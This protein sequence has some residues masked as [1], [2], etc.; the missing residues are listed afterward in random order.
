MRACKCPNCGAN[1]TFDDGREYAFCQFCG[2][3]IDL[4]DQRTMHTEH[5]IDEAKIKESEA[6]AKNADS[7]HRVV[8]VFV[9]PFEE[10]KRKKQEQ[11]A[12]IR[13]FE[14]QTRIRQKELEEQMHARQKESRE[15]FGKFMG[16]L[17]VGLA[18]CVY[19]LITHPKQ[20]IIILACVLTIG[21][22]SSY[23]KNI[24]TSA[25]IEAGEV[26]YPKISSTYT[27]YRDV[28]KAL[29]DAGFKNI[30]AIPVHDLD[31]YQTY[32][33][34]EI[35]EMTVDGAP[36]PTVGEWYDAYTPIV[37]KYHVIK[38]NTTSSSSSREAFDDAIADTQ[39]KLEEA[40]DSTIDL[41]LATL[42][43]AS[44]AS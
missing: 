11:E 33:V 12:R 38:S 16:G 6:K 21:A 44:S 42:D 13:E 5:I 30:S 25:R 35:I 26:Q 9:S 1:L 15:A 32:R 4:M 2:A 27:D 3:K 7:I 18:H 10:R 19:Y 34:N 41:F 28:R 36:T 20:A 39:D 14:E 40:L 31:S 37:I 24:N 43:E 23:I 8:D 17:G 22:G 29:R